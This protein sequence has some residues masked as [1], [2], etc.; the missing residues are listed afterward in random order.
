MRTKWKS[1]ERP[2]RGAG[3]VADAAPGDWERRCGQAWPRQR[4]PWVPGERVTI[5]G[6]RGLPGKRLL[7]TEAVWPSWDGMGVRRPLSLFRGLWDSF[8][9]QRRERERLFSGPSQAHF[10]PCG[11][12]RRSPC[13]LPPTLQDAQCLCDWPPAGVHGLRQ[14]LGCPHTSPFLL[15]RPQPALVSLILRGQ[16]HGR[17]RFLPSGRLTAIH[18]HSS[19]LLLICHH[20]PSRHLSFARETVG[21]TWRLLPSRLLFAPGTIVALVCSLPVHLCWPWAGTRGRCSVTPAGPAPGK[22][23]PEWE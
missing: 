4:G 5:S 23:G 17:L 10:P 20:N 22:G 3:P 15:L 6:E 14:G 2:F 8:R 18:A 12:C 7:C 11:P 9:P 16:R 1:L 19:S 21:P 13:L